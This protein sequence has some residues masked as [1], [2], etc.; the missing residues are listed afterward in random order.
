MS[1]DVLKLYRGEDVVRQYADDVDPDQYVEDGEFTVL[2][3]VPW[4]EPE[5]AYLETGYKAHVPEPP[6]EQEVGMDLVDTPEDVAEREG[7]HERIQSEMLNEEKE[8][9]V[10]AEEM[11][12]PPPVWNEVPDLI[13][14]DGD[15][16]PEDLRPEKRKTEEISRAQRKRRHKED[17]QGD[18]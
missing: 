16:L 4:K 15:I 2:P 8:K 7:I 11:L 5:R 12:E 1:L 13:L 6:I 3:E 14:D 17:L 18:K 9:V 10:Q